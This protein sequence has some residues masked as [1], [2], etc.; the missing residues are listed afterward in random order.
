MKSLAWIVLRVALCAA[1]LGYVSSRTSIHDTVKVAAGETYEP[2][3]LV[4]LE[5]TGAVVIQA[6]QER[7]VPREQIETGADGAVHVYWGLASLA[8]RGNGYL[9]LAAIA[10]Y[11]IQPLLQIVRFQWMLRLQGIRVG[12]LHAGAVCFIGNF[13]NFVIPGTT[14]GDLIRAGY[15]MRGEHDRHGALAAISLD[16]LTGMAGVFALAALAGWLGPSQEA[17]IRRAALVSGLMAVGMIVGYMVLTGWL[18][19]GRLLHRLPFGGH[20]ERFY[21]AL[22]VGRGGWGRLGASVV[23]TVILQSG[24][25]AAFSV[26]AVALGMA[27]AWSTYFVCLPV[28]LVIA[29]IPIVPMGLGT[30]E[31]AMIALLAGHVGS[32]S[33]VLGLALTM[34]LIGLVWAL[35]GGV[36]PFVWRPIRQGAV[37]GATTGVEPVEASCERR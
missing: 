22:S 16:R 28:S 32:A 27:P 30:L 9:L 36:L 8:R 18:A 29:S 23:L 34:R 11:G 21:T 15:M 7:F 25:M 3:R 1:A 12:W 37:G 35:P 31:A 14:G 17:I 33:Q 13:Y 5:S 6:G 26:A 19:M 20:L 4:S 24:S 2:V 10:L